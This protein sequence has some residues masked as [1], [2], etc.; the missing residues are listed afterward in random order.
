MIWWFWKDWNEMISEHLC[1]NESQDVC[2][3]NGSWNQTQDQIWH[4]IHLNLILIFHYSLGP[5]IVH[6]NNIA[7]YSKIILKNSTSWLSFKSILS[8]LASHQT[9]RQ[10][11][12]NWSRDV[13]RMILNDYSTSG[14]INELFT[15]HHNS[16]CYIY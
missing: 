11:W 6:N 15:I 9:M 8:V 16:I 2:F 3:E 4:H 12:C 1:E 13:L 7:K 14:N 5:N 10:L